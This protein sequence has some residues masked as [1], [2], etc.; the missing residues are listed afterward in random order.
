MNDSIKMRVIGAEEVPGIYAID[1]VHA[2]NLM[3]A[4]G[5]CFVK[6]ATYKASISCDKNFHK[7]A[8]SKS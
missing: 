4:I 3:T 2:N 7:S 1:Y 8:L 5:K 6:V